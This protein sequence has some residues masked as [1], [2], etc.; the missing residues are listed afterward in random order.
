MV[1]PWSRDAQSAVLLSPEDGH[2]D[3]RE[4]IQV[5]KLWC[6]AGHLWT[7]LR[8]VEVKRDGQAT[9]STGELAIHCELCPEPD[10]CAA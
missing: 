9:S 4:S 1:W 10:P 6:G 5:I 7:S 8:G 2:Q 3:I